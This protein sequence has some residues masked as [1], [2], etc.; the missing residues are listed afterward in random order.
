M[1]RIEKFLIKR[2]FKVGVLFREYNAKI[3]IKCRINIKE[4]F[5]IITI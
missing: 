5:K 3:I 1:K 4:S 2:G